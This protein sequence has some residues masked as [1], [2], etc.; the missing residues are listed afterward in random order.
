MHK[1]GYIAHR[2]LEVIKPKTANW[3]IKRM[4]LCEWVVRHGDNFFTNLINPDESPF[5]VDGRLNHQC[6]R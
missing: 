4:T 6:H 3:E 1:N 5:T 2:P